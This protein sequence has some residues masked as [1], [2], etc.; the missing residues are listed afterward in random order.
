MKFN[1]S[2]NDELFQKLEE[3]AKKNYLSRSGLVSLAVQNYLQNNQAMKA[4]GQFP[5][6]M[7]KLEQMQNDAK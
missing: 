2:M 3:E 7:A 5:E 6:I 1:V 4:I